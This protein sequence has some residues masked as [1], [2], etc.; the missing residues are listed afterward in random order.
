M[1]FFFETESSYFR[2]IASYYLTP[3]FLFS[4]FARLFS[5][6][7]NERIDHTLLY[8]VLHVPTLDMKNYL[9][10]QHP[11]HNRVYYKLS[12]ALA[13]AELKVASRQLQ[14][15]CAEIGIEELEGVRYLSLTTEKELTSFD[16]EILSRLSFVFALFE[17]VVQDEKTLLLPILQQDYHYL[18]PKI[19]S[20]LKYQGKTNELFTKM[21]INVALL[22]SDFSHQD[23]LSLLDPVAGRGTTLYE[24]AV[25][26]FDV[27]GVE[28]EASSSLAMTQF[29]KKYLKDERYKHTHQRRMV[30]GKNKAQGVYAEEFE[31]ARD[32]A[33][34][35]SIET[36]QHFNIITGPS[37]QCASYFKSESFHLMVG[38]LPYGVA[39][40]NTSDSSSRSVTRNPLELISECLPQ[41]KKVLKKGGVIVLAWNSFLISRQVLAKTFEDLGF[42]VLS[43]EPYGDFEHMVDKAIK[44]DIIVAKK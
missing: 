9:I 8:E 34:F 13:L 7:L 32:K 18:D 31:Y 41:W 10:L 3:Q 20:L 33:D 23:Q 44:R 17:G 25:Y 1:R 37:Q 24:S 36:R 38:D 43:E 4:I 40:G 26:G 14:T 29:F 19:S 39:H 42:E 35:K 27:T 11:G 30:S 21:M 28:L 5:E 22:S 12:G 16:F 6:S 2:R 15:P